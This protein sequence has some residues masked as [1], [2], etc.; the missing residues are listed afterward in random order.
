M[1]G[2]DFIKELYVHMGFHPAW[3]YREVHELVFEDGVLQSHK[4]CSQ[5]MNRV[6]LDLAGKDRPTS[7]SDEDVKR[8]I[9]GCYSL[10]YTR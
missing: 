3:K 4:D 8:W 2:R 1:L 7:T 5:D 9:S 6:R 10:E